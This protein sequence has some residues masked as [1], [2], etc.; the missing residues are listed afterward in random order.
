MQVASGIENADDTFML[1]WNRQ[2]LDYHYMEINGAKIAGFTVQSGDTDGAL[3]Q[4][5]NARFEETGVIAEVDAQGRL[6]LIAKD[7]RNIHITYYDSG[8]DA[9]GNGAASGRFD[10]LGSDL[11]ALIGLRDGD[12]GFNVFAAHNALRR[13]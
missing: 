4:A 6:E 7:G 5:I 2:K 13:V 1:W 11:E 9:S 12:G 8:T 3:Q 10:N